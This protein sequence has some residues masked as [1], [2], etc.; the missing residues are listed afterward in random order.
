VAVAVVELDCQRDVGDLHG[1]GSSGVGAADDDALA[2][3]G[4]SPGVVVDP[5]CRS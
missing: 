5:N 3:D 2:S 4:D 1:Q